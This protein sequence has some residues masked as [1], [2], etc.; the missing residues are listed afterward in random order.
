MQDAETIRAQTAALIATSRWVA[1]Q[2]RQ[3]LQETCWLRFHPP[4]FIHG[5]ADSGGPAVP[6]T[7]PDSPLLREK[8]RQAIERRRMPSR[9]PDRLG[10]VVGVGHICAVCERAV[11]TGE[12]D[13]EL[14]FTRDG[15]RAPMVYHVHVRC[16]SAWV[17]T[18]RNSSDGHHPR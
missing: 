16:Y 9:E 4:G 15:K 14:F 17:R 10:G 18:I 8:A 1:A 5:G 6:L 13:L 12:T 2:A 11:T 3:S 7:R